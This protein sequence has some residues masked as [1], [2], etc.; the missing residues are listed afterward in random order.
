MAEAALTRTSAALDASFEGKMSVYLTPRIFW[1]GAATYGD[2]VQLISYLDRNYTAVE[3]WSYFAHEGTHA[4][5]QDLAGAFENPEQEGHPDGVL[6]EGLA[7]WASGGHY[8]QEPLDMWAAVIA[9]SDAYIPLSELREGP[10]Y[11]FQHEISYLE[12]ASF[13]KYLIAAYGLD[14]FKKLYGLATG[15][16]AHDQR[17]VE[18]L[19]GQNYEQ[20]ER[21]WLDHLDGLEPTLEQA[22]T[23]HLTRRSFDLTRRYETELDPDARI[24]PSSPP[25]AWTTD[26]LEIFLHRKE[27]PKNI[28]LETSLIAAQ[29]RLYGGDLKG[30][31]LLLDDIEAALDA[32]EREDALDRPSQVAR[33]LILELVAA[34]DRA[35][36]TADAGAYLSTVRPTTALAEEKVVADRLGSPFTAYRQEVVRLDVA[37]DGLS[38]Q[39]VVLIHSELAQELACLMAPVCHET[40]TE[41][42]QLQTVT[43]ARTQ[44]GWLMTSRAAVGAILAPLPAARD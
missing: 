38:A 31:A 4:L 43:F 39:G 24:L 22:E 20:L 25:P 36:L 26:T 14:R 33:K 32:K 2:K 41:D 37:D 1:Q 3:I 11:D 9:A 6:V 40:M 8:R 19:Y 42:G 13:V 16:P 17:S 29:E 18:R 27:T 30:A 15:D 10:F 35:V 44:D 28:V 21:A 7:V 34:Q 23:W 5:A 12:A